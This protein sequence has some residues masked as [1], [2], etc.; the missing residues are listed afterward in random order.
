MHKL[1]ISDVYCGA[2]FHHINSLE[3]RNTERTVTLHTPYSYHNYT[4]DIYLKT[5]FATG[6][7]LCK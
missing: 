4:T 6:N 5:A 3:V 7:V 2:V 1:D